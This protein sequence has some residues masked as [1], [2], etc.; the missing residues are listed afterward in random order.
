ME[1]E[2]EN[3]G[4]RS[5]EVDKGQMNREEKEKDDSSQLGSLVQKRGR[6]FVASLNMQH[7]SS[8]SQV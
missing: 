4:M 5:E 3:G 2:D 1:R 7:F 6:L 8:L